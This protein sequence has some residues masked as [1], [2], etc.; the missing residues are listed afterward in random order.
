MKQPFTILCRSGTRASTARANT[1]DVQVLVSVPRPPACFFFNVPYIWVI[2]SPIS[3]VDV[4]DCAGN[5]P[6]LL[7]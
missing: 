5:A 7:L 3:N 1:S 4:M 2:N 6:P